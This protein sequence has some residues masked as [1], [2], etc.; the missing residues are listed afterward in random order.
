MYNTAL[1]ILKEINGTG[2]IA[3]IVGGFVRDYILGI[4]S[5]DIDIATSATPDII[6]SLYEVVEDNSRFGSL[7]IKKNNYIFEIT[8]FR[9]E[10]EYNNRFP[11]IE[12]TDSLIEDLKRR[13]FTI[14]AICMD[15]FESIIDLMGGIE[16]I[17][18]KTIRSIGNVDIKLNE[19][20]LRILRA[21]R[22]MG[23]LDFTLDESLEKSIIKNKEL[24][25][26]LSKKRINSEISK[27][28]KKS[29]DE[30]KRLEI[31]KYIKEEL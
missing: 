30:L 4:K 19:D 8:T 20:P 28:N 10:L 3:Y 24:I 11:K 16:D 23:Y 9:I 22:F 18:K 7:K 1:S 15:E 13:D 21:I 6:A 29:I 31:D 5:T 17:E 27:M 26:T 12:F 14:N 2:Y 25:K